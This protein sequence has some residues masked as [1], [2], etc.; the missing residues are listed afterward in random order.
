MVVVVGS[1]L[2][3][4]LRN[5]HG[6]VLLFCDV[7]GNASLGSFT[8]VCV[9]ECVWVCVSV[10]VC[11]C[12]C[13]CVCVSV[14]LC[15]W[16]CVFV[17]LCVCVCLFV[18][19]CVQGTWSIGHFSVPVH[20][21]WFFKYTNFSHTHTHNPTSHTYSMYTHTQTAHRGG[22]VSMY[23]WPPVWLVWNQ[24]YDNWQFLFSFANR[25]IQTSQT[26][27]QQYTNTFPLVFFA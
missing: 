6:S 7:I 11:E 18:C 13:E 10:C 26:G 5:T 3:C 1:L 21:T 24:L 17:C 12:V 16:V 25:L 23:H 8:H 9:C 19:V 15:V 22:E 27:G 4:R 20:C 2:D 14:W